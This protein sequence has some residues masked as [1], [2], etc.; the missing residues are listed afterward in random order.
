MPSI[1]FISLERCQNAALAVQASFAT[2]K[3]AVL[4]IPMV[5]HSFSHTQAMLGP[6]SPHIRLALGSARDPSSICPGSLYRSNR[7]G[8]FDGTRVVKDC[9]TM[10]K[11]P[12]PYCLA[13]SFLEIKRNPKTVT[14]RCNAWSL[15]WKM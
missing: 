7:D 12:L 1:S 3:T 15:L 8:R 9:F 6:R 5:L 2:T 4:Q 10:W 11:T 13:R 14:G